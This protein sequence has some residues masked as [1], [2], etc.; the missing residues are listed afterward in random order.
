M[1][2]ELGQRLSCEFLQFDTFNAEAGLS[3]KALPPDSF[4]ASADRTVVG[5]ELTGTVDRVHPVGVFVHVADGVDGLVASERSTAGLLSAPTGD[6][7]AGEEISVV[8][9]DIERPQ[10]RVFF[11][12]SKTSRRGEVRC[13]LGAFL[14]ER[15]QSGRV[16]GASSC[17]CGAGWLGAR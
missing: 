2:V 6:F 10:R 12:R 4:Q 15:D 3:S 1:S 7:E 5:Q 11:S 17:K 13:A 9:T 16:G 14:L 8:L